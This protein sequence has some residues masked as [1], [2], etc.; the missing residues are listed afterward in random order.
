MV[1]LSTFSCI[2]N[3]KQKS[4]NLDTFIEIKEPVKNLNCQLYTCLN[5]IKDKK[6]ANL[7]PLSCKPDNTSKS[8]VTIPDDLQLTTDERNILSKGTKFIPTSYTTS[9][10]TTD[11]LDAFYRRV[12]LHAHF[13]NPN[14]DDPTNTI[15]ANVVESTTVL[16]K[17]KP[18]STW[19]PKVQHKAVQEFI[20]RCKYDID[21]I[22]RPRHNHDNMSTQEKTALRH[23]KSRQDIVIKQ[24][25]KGGAIVVWRKDLYIQKA[26]RHLSNTEFYV[27]VESDTTKTIH[28][29]CQE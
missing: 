13:N 12:L 16:D 21:K 6:F 10:K 25:D 3:K 29:S 9:Q 19:T 28:Y 8:V 20:G 2:K 27:H 14:E 11:D 7:Q 26:N 18:R 23:L 5:N 1:T 22:S 17:F 15:T 4:V 24:A